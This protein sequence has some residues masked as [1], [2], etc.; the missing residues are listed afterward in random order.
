MSQIHNNNVKT[1][2]NE[3]MSNH[4]KQEINTVIEMLKEGKLVDRQILQDHIIT[5]VRLEATLNKQTIYQ[6]GIS[7]CGPND[8]FDAE[9]GRKIANGRAFKAMAKRVLDNKERWGLI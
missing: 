4:S 3:I 6:C 8:K 7:T 5:C 2:E 1:T 9:L